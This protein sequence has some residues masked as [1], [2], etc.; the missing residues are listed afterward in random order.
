MKTKT[1]N[2]V[3]NEDVPL[4]EDYEETEYYYE[5]IG[6]NEDLSQPIKGETTYTSKY[7]PIVKCV[8]AVYDVEEKDKAG[9]KPILTLRMKKGI[10]QLM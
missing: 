1:L 2:V 9:A 10:R 3:K 6:W 7:N 5:N 8:V 4:L